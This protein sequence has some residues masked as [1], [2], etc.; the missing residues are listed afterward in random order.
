MFD[1]EQLVRDCLEA[2]QETDP[3]TAVHEV[4][5][6]AVRHPASVVRALGEP[7]KAGI[8]ILHQA[9]DLTVLNVLWGPRMNLHPHNH[10]MWAVIGVYGGREDNTFY[11]RSEGGLTK[12]GVKVLDEKD[13]IALGEPII[14]SVA[15]PLDQLTAAIHVYPGDFFNTPRSEWDPQTF[16]EHPYDVEHTLRVFEESNR[17]LKE[18]HRL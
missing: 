4:V 7:K 9:P 1:A 18:A 11:R 16:E 6:R 5:A 15:N 3:R 17:R 2:L 14:H 13:T 10:N 8:D 12:H